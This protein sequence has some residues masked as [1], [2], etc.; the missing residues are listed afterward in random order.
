[1][2]VHQCENSGSYLRKIVFAVTRSVHRGFGVCYGVFS[3][4][5]HL[6]R[7]LCLKRPFSRLN[8]RNQRFF[9]LLHN[10]AAIPI[11]QCCSCELFPNP[12]EKFAIFR[13][14]YIHP[15]STTYI[16]I[17]FCLANCDP[18]SARIYQIQYETIII[19]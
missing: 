16:S 8:S 10:F 14:S 4:L 7:T 19:I 18:T 9:S 17:N 13:I 15:L 11:G 6:E 3:L 5:Y 12:N 1:M 2:S